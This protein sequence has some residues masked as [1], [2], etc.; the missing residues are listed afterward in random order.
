MRKRMHLRAILALVASVLGLLL[1]A[2]IAAQTSG[3]VYRVSMRLPAA[4]GVVSDCSMEGYVL[5]TVQL[6][7]G[8][9]VLSANGQA[10]EANGTPGPPLFLHPLTDV[11]WQRKYDAGRGLSGVFNGCYG[12]TYGANGYHGAF[13][14]TFASKKGVQGQTTV[15]FTWYFDYY[16]TPGNSIRE[17]FAMFAGD[18]PFPAWTGQNVTARV[19][20]MFDFAYY[21]KEGRT[22]VSPYQSITGGLG[23]YFEFDLVIEKI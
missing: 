21:L 16:V 5:A 18:I 6:R 14:M 10:L 20:G 7:N 4:M 11:A 23:R 19:K 8:G 17:H 12:E 9:N 2:P 13:F 15:S 22:I 1:P 3:D